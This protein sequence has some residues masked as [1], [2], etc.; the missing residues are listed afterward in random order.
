MK[1]L[2]LLLGSLH[3]KNLVLVFIY[4]DSS[5][6][7]SLMSAYLW[8][9]SVLLHLSLAPALCSNGFVNIPQY[10]IQAPLLGILNIWF[11]LSLFLSKAAVDILAC[12][13]WWTYILLLLGKYLRMHLLG[14]RAGIFYLQR[15]LPQ[16][17][18]RCFIIFHPQQQYVWILVAPR[19]Q[20]HLV[21]PVFWT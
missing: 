13:W 1:W 18:S 4:V 15:K 2:C 11:F 20:Q 7:Y 10:I 3:Q 8:E 16:S 12:L 14:C 21:W 17:S 9:S 6:M 19:P 5:C